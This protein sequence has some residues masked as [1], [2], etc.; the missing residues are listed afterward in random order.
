MGRRFNIYQLGF[1]LLLS[2]GFLVMN[3]WMV[4]AQTLSG[5]V[6]IELDYC[7]TPNQ[8][9]LALVG[10]PV[11]A[12]DI[13]W[14]E[15][16]NSNTV[17]ELTESAGKLTYTS[18]IAGKYYVTYTDGGV[19]YNTTTVST[20]KELVVN[21]NFE[22]GNVGFTTEYTYVPNPSLG[23]A[24]GKYAVDVD[25]QP[26]YRNFNGNKDH[27]KGDG[28]GLYMIVDGTSNLVVWK[29]TIEVK[30]NTTYYLSAWSLKIFEASNNHANPKLGFSVNGQ[31]IGEKVELVDYSATGDN[32]W[33][34]K[35]R[36]YA[37]WP[38]GSATKATVEVVN[39]VNSSGGNDFGLDDISFGTLAPPVIEISGLNGN[40][41]TCEGTPIS[42]S[43]NSAGGCSSDFSYEWINL[44][45]VNNPILESSS[46]T[47]DIPFP[48][49]EEHGGAWKLVV[50]DY[51]SSD[52]LNFQLL[53][54]ETPDI[55]F[56]TSC[57]TRNQ[58]TGEENTDG[59]IYIAEV[60]GVS[61]QL[62]DEAGSV[63]VDWGQTQFENLSS[64]TYYINSKYTPDVNGCTNSAIVRL[65]S[66]MF[67]IL[68]PDEICQGT[69]ANITVAPSLCCYEWSDKTQS[70]PSNTTESSTYIKSSTLFQNTYVN[71][72]NTYSAGDEV[73]YKQV[74]IFRLEAVNNNLIIKDD[75]KSNF[76]YSV[77]KY[78]FNPNKPSDNY[79]V[80]VKYDPSLSKAE[81]AI[82]SLIVGEVYVIVAN[83]PT[84]APANYS[85]LMYTDAGKMTT[86]LFP[87]VKWYSDAGASNQIASGATLSTDIL[88]PS[89]TQVPGVYDFYVSCCSTCSTDKV[90]ITV[91]PTPT[92]V[93]EQTIC[94]GSST[95]IKPIV[96]NSNGVLIDEEIFTIEY[97]WTVSSKTGVKDQGI[98][99]SSYFQPEMI[100]TITLEDGVACGEVVYLVTARAGGTSGCISNTETVTV[101]VV[102]VNSIGTLSEL[103][104]C[105]EKIAV[106]NWNGLSEPDTDISEARPDYKIIGNAS[107]L[108]DFPTEAMPTGTCY[109]E[110]TNNME[111]WITNKNDE[112]I[113]S[114][115]NQPSTSLIDGNQIILNLEQPSIQEQYTITYQFD[116][117]CGNGLFVK[118][119]PIVIKPRPVVTKTNN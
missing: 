7:I 85:G 44:T 14:Y 48:T 27:T 15:I 97:K 5:D 73:S 83:A 96:T 58:T 70:F 55:T 76:T 3:N 74:G 18:I 36:F 40:V 51:Y 108:L 102:D 66:E 87:D 95:N 29:Q 11:S 42:L 6:S 1:G 13:K 92:L 33:L 19:L 21:G 72:S 34:D 57:I 22:L 38:S 10:L 4:T 107:V 111:W 46:S 63:L 114:G 84:T 110:L 37:T 60:N 31:D 117:R 16:D 47:L 101:Q 115:V 20:A 68:P 80:T 94:S 30:P 61:Y 100:Q 81:R 98:T 28:T 77:Y 53:L 82:K 24:S 23:I 45:D 52:T 56:T 9:T 12:T 67:T 106:A 17:K 93:P 50:Q 109:T 116:V 59:A 75:G 88:F 62:L 112:I 2:M 99:S 35:Y 49:I 119:R 89:G 86:A 69:S 39:Y 64:G 54:L 41:Q 65:S 26:Y 118:T 78:P 8:V 90:T 105:V 43:I 113:Y 79:I 104:E 25:P 71:G 32:P 91:N 103:N